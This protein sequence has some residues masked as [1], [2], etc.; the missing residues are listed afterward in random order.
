MNLEE[1]VKLHVRLIKDACNNF[2]IEDEYPEFYDQLWYY[3]NVLQT[4]GIQEGC[5][6]EDLLH[7]LN[8]THTMI[9][10]DENL[11]GFGLE[12]LKLIWNSALDLHKHNT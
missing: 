10:I 5:K 8:E 12:H 9:V 3:I 4:K 1:T 2:Q 6:K 11:D 7:A